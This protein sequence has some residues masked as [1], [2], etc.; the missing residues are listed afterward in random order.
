MS[1][2][3]AGTLPS[4]VPAAGQ[5]AV[6][7]QSNGGLS[8]R[9]RDIVAPYFEPFY[10]VKVINDYSGAFKNPY[11]GSYG[12]T[13]FFG[14]GHAGTND[15]MVAVAEYGAS[16]I[17]FKRV[18][19]PTPWFGTGTDAVTRTANSIAN[20]NALMDMRYMEA[21]VDGKPGAPHSYGSG[22]IVGPEHGGAA[23]GSFL[24]VI[25][26]CINF[27]NPDGVVAAHELR[28]DSVGTPSSE[29]NWRRLTNEATLTTTNW[30]PPQLTA[31]V[32][33]QRRSYIQS[34]D[35]TANVRWYDR[36]T[37]T[38]VIGSGRTFDYD[39][40]DGFDS[41]I[42]F[43]VPSRDLLICMYPVDGQL[44][45]QWMDVS[46]AQPTLGGTAALSHVVRVAAPWSAGCWCP[47]NNRI[48][49]G[50]IT[51]DG[52]CVYELEIPSTPTEVWNVRRAPFGAGQ[53]LVPPD[54]AAGSGMTYKKFHYDEKVR[55][56]V[57]MPSASASGD[58]T[59]W[60]YRPR[61]T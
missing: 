30:S 56:I 41:G 4:W 26:A 36:N 14:G 5:L 10:S 61:S 60:V 18:C 6:L 1:S 45:V 8:N 57:Y 50:G 22:D 12:C 7:T 2:T 11:W 46:V 25:S 43:Y 53:A 54:V 48:I 35:S 23:N 38:Y 27:H 31:F 51:G 47:H 59:V 15:N 32:G 9:F 49:V 40:A 34:N 19:D 28:F 42:L 16:S 13:V 39:S 24:R 37:N 44:R 17:T 55:A 3:A 21:L 29:R 20:A 52:G 58:D 33:P